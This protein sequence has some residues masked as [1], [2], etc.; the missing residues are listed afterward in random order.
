L[1]G[2]P[3]ADAPGVPGGERRWIR[4]DDGASI[5]YQAFGARDSARAPLLILDGIGCSGWAFR[6]I[7][8]ALAEDRR[9]VLL[10]YRGHGLS[11]DPPRPW[12]L[13]MPTLADD[14]AAALEHDRLDRAV[15]VGFSMGFPVAL[16]LFRRHRRCVSALV[17][18]AGPSGRVLRTFQG[19][20]AFGHVLPFVRAT[21]R[22]ARD[23]TLKAWRAVVPSNLTLGLGLNF[24]VNLDRIAVDDFEFYTRHLA[25][26]NPEL[27]VAMLEE[28]DRH[29]AADILDAIDVPMMVVAGARDTFVPLKT[30]RDL[31]FAVP[32]VR[33]KV[34]DQ[35]THALPAEYPT[36]MTELLARFADDLDRGEL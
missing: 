28:A 10:H 6:R 26:M 18:L 23:L 12:R 36:E 7:I 24:Q 15:V 22:F 29:S 17:S 25:E 34:L 11:V 16:E 4:R 3:A 2:D 27:F 1:A 33:W 35:A 20:Q 14:A 8:P 32:Q 30:M 19:T 5:C 31:A 13:S 9:V 21:T